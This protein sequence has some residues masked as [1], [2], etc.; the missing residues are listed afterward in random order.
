MKFE[1]ENVP[2][3]P[4]HWRQTNNLFISFLSKS[5]R[6]QNQLLLIGRGGMK[7]IGN[8]YVYGIS[9]VTT[10]TS[11]LIAM[12]SVG[13]EENVS[14]EHLHEWTQTLIVV[15]SIIYPL[16]IEQVISELKSFNFLRPLLICLGT[17]LFGIANSD[18]S[19][20][21]QFYARWKSVTRKVSVW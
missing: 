11:I 17:T 21:F 4:T 12:N 10:G 19:Y 20:N 14:V 16:H 7:S 15:A 8:C 3:R 6:K 2:L 1:C 5:N 9:K 18:I 13:M